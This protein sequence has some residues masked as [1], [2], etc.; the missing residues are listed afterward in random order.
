MNIVKGNSI[1][2]N[3][4]HLFYSTVFASVLNAVTLIVLASYLETYHYGLFSV[5]L[6]FAM[7]M[8]YFTD[9]GLSRIVVREASKEKGDL[10]VIITS[11][12]K[13]RISLL[14][15]TFLIGFVLITFLYSEDHQLLQTAYLLIIPMVIGL[16]LQSVGTAYF[17]VVERMEYSGIIRISSSVLLVLT[18]TIG[19]LF[20][21]SPLMISTFY[22]CSYLAGG[23][24]ALLL[25]RRNMAFDFKSKF[26]KGL[27]K[28]IW[29]F[30]ADGFLFV[31]TPQLGPII[32]ESTLSL[33]EVGL[34]AVAYRIPQALQQIPF[35]VAGAYFPVMYRHF[36]NN[37][38]LEHTILNTMQ[39]K[40]MGLMG[41]AM[42][43]PIFFMSDW[44]V[45][46]I[47]GEHWEGA[48]MPLRILA[49]MLTIQMINIALADGLTTQSKQSRRTA[50]QA[51]SLVIGIGLYIVLSKAHGVIGAAFAGVSLELVALCGYIIC[52]PQRFIL[53]KNAILPYLLF[54]LF[55]L[56]LLDWL[57]SSVP[58]MAAI[59]GF[60][61]IG[62]I[63]IAD[64]SMNEKA[65]DLVRER[66]DRKRQESKGV[67]HGA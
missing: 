3:I 27:L 45:P 51:V 46:L 49:I 17:Q 10:P 4:L 18:I 40:I 39:I 8:G 54:F 60:L 21:F 9:A 37:R 24:I 41:M 14:V 16:M 58:L 38:V 23:I 67:K 63:V 7:I 11:Y 47:F 5:V 36:Q 6:A 25:V 20:S 59:T 32:L 50:V 26:H 52:T 42:T 15:I 29:P 28:D 30:T 53:V 48:S 62:A 22:G 65:V 2:K 66:Q 13:L 64:K 19:M 44:I 33:S 43:I 1:A 34:F 31:M 61:L 12:L 56:F 55:S 57:L 35:V